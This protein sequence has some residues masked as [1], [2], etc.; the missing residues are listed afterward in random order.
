M[1]PA[2]APHVVVSQIQIEPGLAAADRP[3]LDRSQAPDPKAFRHFEHLRPNACWQSDLT[4]GIVRPGITSYR[5]ARPKLSS[6]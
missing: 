5:P 6:R 4:D 2:A 1:Q 3:G